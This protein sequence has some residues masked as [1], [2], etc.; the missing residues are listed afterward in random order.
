MIVL[1]KY[2]VLKKYFNYDFFRGVQEEVIDALLKK[3]KV[4]AIMA[5]GSGKSICFQIPGIILDGLTIVISPL[6]SL[7][8]DQVRSLKKH[9]INT[10]YLISDMHFFEVNNVYQA[11][12]NNELK[13]LYLSPEK[14]MNKKFIS[15][16][17][18]VKISQIIV[19][20]AHSI[21]MWGLDFRKSYQDIPLFISNLESKPNIAFFTATAPDKVVKD[22]MKVMGLYDLKIIKTTSD[23]E[24]LFYGL[25]KPKIKFDYLLKYLMRHQN[26]KVIVY[27]L[28]RKRCEELF[29][30]LS[31]LNF[32]TTFFHGG[33]NNEVKK[34]NQKSFSTNN[35]NIMIA[36]NAFG[37]GIDISDIRSVLL[38][39][40]PISLEDLSQQFG[41]CSR[42]RN[43]GECILI[44][45]EKDIKTCQYF[46]DSDKE[47]LKQFKKVLQF[48]ETKDCLHQFLV[49]YFDKEKICKCFNCSNCLKHKMRK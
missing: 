25:V 43:R 47:K 1:N 37:M 28:T 42:D 36:T 17:K 5:T 2:E 3:E 18:K 31:I 23:R 48:V 11:L 19:D 27:V 35:K 14:L 10:A 33:L 4:L 6:I 41:R 44:F 13:F 7:I 32:K 39:D 26:E 21:S 29:E 9:K 34:E 16:I 15:V 12:E 46:I 24:N 22:I 38:Y 30:K 8:I 45:D 49:N 20:E 40:L